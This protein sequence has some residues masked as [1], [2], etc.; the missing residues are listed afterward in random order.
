MN[1]Y[2]SILIWLFICSAILP[3]QQKALAQHSE[4]GVKVVFSGALMFGPYY[5]YWIDDHNALNTS[6]LAAIEEKGVLIVP[7]ALNAG[8]SAH[9]FNNQWRPEMGLQ[10]TY[11]ISPKRSKA[12]DD[13]K[14]VSILSLVPGVQFRWDNTNQNLQSR[15]WLGYIFK[16][17]QSGKKLKILPLGLDFSYGYKFN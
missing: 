16:K 12:F 13:P 1:V 7:F 6:I 2:K 14:G 17:P 11:L 10:Y 8:Y 15:I 5:T 4:I 9:F 3:F